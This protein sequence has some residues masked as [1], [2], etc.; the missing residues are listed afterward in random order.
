MCKL[1][2]ITLLATKS[3]QRQLQRDTLSETLSTWGSLTPKRDLLTAPNKTGRCAMN[4]GTTSIRRSSPLSAPSSA[5][6]S[7]NGCVKSS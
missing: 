4:G 3:R 6:T 2:S 1:C 7:L 5:G